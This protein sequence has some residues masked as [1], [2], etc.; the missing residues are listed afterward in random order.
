MC[1]I[2]GVAADAVPGFFLGQFTAAAAALAQ[3][4][5]SRCNYL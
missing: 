3:H 5:L 2:G 1:L 4:S